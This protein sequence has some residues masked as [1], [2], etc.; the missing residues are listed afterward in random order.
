MPSYIDEVSQK[1]Q[2]KKSSKLCFAPHPWSVPIHGK[3][4]QLALEADTSPYLKTKQVQHVYN[5]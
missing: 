2:H 4:V 1:F 3:R 5:P